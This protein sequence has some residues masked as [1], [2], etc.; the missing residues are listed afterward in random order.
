MLIYWAKTHH[1]KRET[2]LGAMKEVSI[3][4]NTEMS[5]CM[6]TL[7]HQNV[8][9]NHNSMI[10]NKS[11]E[12]VVKLKYLGKI[13]TNQDYVLKEIK[14]RL[15]LENACCHSVQNLLSSRPL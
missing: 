4:V 14:S 5:D 12:N 10:A 8:V 11:F 1:N 6:F 15:N 3:V 7:C 2:S 9:Q 13:V